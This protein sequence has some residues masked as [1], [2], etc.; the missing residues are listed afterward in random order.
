M[1]FCEVSLA[2]CHVTLHPERVKDKQQLSVKKARRQG[3]IHVD[4]N[5]LEDPLP[6]NPLEDPL[7]FNPLEDPLPFNLLED[8]LP[9]NIMYS[10][11]RII[12]KLGVWLSGVKKRPEVWR[13]HNCF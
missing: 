1:I 13:R 4:Y 10:Q 5:L 12:K 3:W 2:S 6:F 9:F 7:P 8:P 11:L